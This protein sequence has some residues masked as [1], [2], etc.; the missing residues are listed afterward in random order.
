MCLESYIGNDYAN[1]EYNAKTE[2]KL[3]RY[4]NLTSEI[5]TRIALE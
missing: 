5:T 1:F 2:Q 4:L 3:N